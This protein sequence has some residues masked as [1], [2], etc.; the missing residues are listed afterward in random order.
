MIR[1]KNRKKKYWWKLEWRQT[2]GAHAC[3]PYLW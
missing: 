3:I 2:V 1:K